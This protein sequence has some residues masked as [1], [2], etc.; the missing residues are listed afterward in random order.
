MKYA[1]MNTKYYYVDFRPFKYQTKTHKHIKNC[2]EN[3]GYILLHEVECPYN[4][5]LEYDYAFI[6]NGWCGSYLY[7]IM[8]EDKSEYYENNRIKTEYAINN[9]YLIKLNSDNIYNIKT[10]INQALNK[11]FLSSPLTNNTKT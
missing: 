4:I 7:Y 8:I 6:Y 1:N 9:A 10:I 11:W 2:F 5:N 3:M